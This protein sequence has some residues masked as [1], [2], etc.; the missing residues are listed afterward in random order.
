MPAPDVSPLASQIIAKTPE[1][2]RKLTKYRDEN[3]EAEVHCNSLEAEISRVKEC[4]D[5]QKLLRQNMEKQ[6]TN[7][8]VLSDSDNEGVKANSGDREASAASE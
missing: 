8:N 2:L 7:K 1:L 4:I 5:A 6:D 3:M